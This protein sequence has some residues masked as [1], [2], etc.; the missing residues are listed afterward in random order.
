MALSRYGQ[1]TTG[2][3]KEAATISE[4]DQAAA[5]YNTAFILT[6]QERNF[7]PDERP[8]DY[9]LPAHER[10]A[11]SGVMFDNTNFPWMQSMST[12][13]KTIGHLLREAG[14]YTACKGQWHL[15]R[16]FETDNTLAAP[17]K[18]FTR[19]TEAYGFS[20]YLGAG[21]TEQ[22]L[23]SGGESGQSAPRDVL[24]HG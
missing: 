11:K 23:V 1:G 10:L 17:T 9:R 18:V 4:G 6:V 7:H 12:E 22:A 21:E 20:D 16:E 19:E 3:N 24:R 2:F 5:P 8:K 13:I 14:Y 15:T